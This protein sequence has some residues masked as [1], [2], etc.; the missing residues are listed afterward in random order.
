MRPWR[1]LT[2]GRTEICL[3]PSLVL[4]A[5]YACACGHR[6][7]MAVGFL[8]ILMHEGSHALVGV[9]LGQRLER[10]E[11][12][13]LGAVLRVEED[14]KLSAW[15]RLAMLSGGPGM[16]FLL[17][18]AALM[19]TRQGLIDAAWGRILFVS[20]LSI[21]MMNLLPALP[22]D[23]GRILLLGLECLLPARLA[24]RIMQGIGSALGIGLIA[25][26]VIV[27]WRCGGW[28]LSLAMA[29]CCLLYGSAVSMMTSAMAEYRFLLD[30]KILLEQRGYLRVS[31]LAAL[32]TQTLRQL[33]R[34][35]PRA[36]ACIFLCYEAGSMHFQGMLTETELLQQYFTSPE[37]RL[38][39]A[40]RQCTRQPAHGEIGTN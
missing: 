31:V 1:I 10:V 26:N 27:T 40:V 36:R 19:L 8:S 24:R 6:A 17:C 23:G 15:K 14:A 21:L 39:E 12:T 7:Y 34:I 30:R 13:P 20:N 32:H 35:L 18:S 9:L 2:I 33:V 11:L 25:L 22:L 16:T 38:G 37:R 29:G 28:N 4:Y 5:C 3:H